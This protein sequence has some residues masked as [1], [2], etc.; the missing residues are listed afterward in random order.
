MHQYTDRLYV[1]ALGLS[2]DASKSL[3]AK[4]QRYFKGGPTSQFTGGDR[5]VG[6]QVRVA[7]GSTF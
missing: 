6:E 5:K 4:M 3:S 7:K 1:P 2:V